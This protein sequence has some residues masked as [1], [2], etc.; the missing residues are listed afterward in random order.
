MIECKICIPSDKIS[1]KEKIDINRII[2]TSK[3]LNKYTCIDKDKG[4]GYFLEL[5]LNQKKA[6]KEKAITLDS[7]KNKGGINNY[8]SVYLN[9]I[10]KIKEN[11]FV[12]LNLLTA[13]LT[14]M[15]EEKV[16]NN[17]TLNMISVETKRIID[18]MYNLSNYYYVSG[19]MALLKSDFDYDKE[20]ELYDTLQR[21]SSGEKIPFKQ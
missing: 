3:Y 18:T 9:L 13:I 19:I 21:I 6:L 17:K 8:N 2:E 4:N 12:N 1:P 5:N 20:G 16:I 11:Y 15:L 10:E 14:Q 7:L